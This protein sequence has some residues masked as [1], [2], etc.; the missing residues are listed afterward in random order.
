MDEHALALVQ[1]RLDAQVGPHGAADLNH[2]RGFFQAKTLG[3]RKQ[4]TL[5]DRHVFRIAA[6]REQT[7]NFS[8]GF[9]VCIT[10]IL[11]HA[12][13]LQ[14]N[15]VRCPWWRRVRAHRLQNIATVDAR[16]LHLHQD[17]A[18]SQLRNVYVLQL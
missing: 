7:A 5:R 4:L 12:G 17:L 13:G 11:N 16:G 6:A 9:P 8:A 10:G 18:G 15:D 1:A 3:Q 2:C 14:S